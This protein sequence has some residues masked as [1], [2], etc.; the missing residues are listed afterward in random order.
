MVLGHTYDNSSNITQIVDPKARPSTLWQYQQT[1]CQRLHRRHRH[2]VTSHDSNRRHRQTHFI[3][4]YTSKCEL[5]IQCSRP[6]SRRNQNRKFCNLPH[7]L[8]IRPPRK[9]INHHKPRQ[10]KSSLCL[11]HC[12]TV[13]NSRKERKHRQC[14]P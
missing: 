10:L 5:R 3:Y 9:H 8:H 2:R 7:R 6:S 11:Q 14:I 13:G 4:I 12:R 1:F